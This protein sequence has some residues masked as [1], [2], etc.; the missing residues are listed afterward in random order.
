MS[1]SSTPPTELIPQKEDNVQTVASEQGNPFHGFD[2]GDHLI[3]VEVSSIRPNRAKFAEHT[4]TS[5]ESRPDRDIQARP[6]A[7]DGRMGY[8]SSTQRP[9]M[10]NR[11]HAR[12]LAIGQGTSTPLL[13]DPQLPNE[14]TR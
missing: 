11:H 12:S 13:V 2:W 1:E 3:T 6:R 14:G 9:A 4:T 10:G 7:L 5:R 8:S